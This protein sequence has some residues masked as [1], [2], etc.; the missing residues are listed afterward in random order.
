MRHGLKDLI[1]VRNELDTIPLFRA[2]LKQLLRKKQV[3]E[4]TIDK[5]SL[6]SEEILSSTIS[7]GYVGI[8]GNPNPQNG[9]DIEVTVAVECDHSV[10]L[11]FCDEAPPFDP[12]FAGAQS[13]YPDRASYVRRYGYN[14]IELRVED[15]PRKGD[16]PS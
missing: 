3:S 12:L 2:L 6:I 15:A 11:Q 14:I 13:A 5:V 10:Y 8:E 16:G 4:E 7:H 1:S 9:S